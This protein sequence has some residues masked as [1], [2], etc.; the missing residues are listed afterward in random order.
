ML[1][2]DNQPSAAKAILVLMLDNQPSA[3]KAILVLMLDNQPSAAKC[4]CRITNLQQPRY[5]MGNQPSTARDIL[6]ADVA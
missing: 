3:D 4:Q 2:L 5:D 1:M 6:S